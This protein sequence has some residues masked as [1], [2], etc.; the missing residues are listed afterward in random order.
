[1]PKYYGGKPTPSNPEGLRECPNC[2]PECLESES[3]AC[4]SCCWSPDGVN[5]V[6]NEDCNN[7]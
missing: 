2:T 6:C 4:D 3:G 1:M 7:H 5:S